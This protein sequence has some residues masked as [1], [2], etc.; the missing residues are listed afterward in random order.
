M[1]S[2]RALDEAEIRRRIEAGVAAI[3]AMD[4]E[5]VMALYA[6]D[7]VSFDVEPPL[8]H[9]GTEAKRKNW[10]AV[11][12]I[13]QAPLGYEV[14]DLSLSVGDDVAFAYSLNRISGTLRNGQRSEVWVRWTAG[15]RKVDGVWLITHDHASVPADFASGN[16][17]VDL[18]P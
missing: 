13:Y 14:R 3:R 6:P 18:E 5:G 16:A 10:S 15:L 7:I 12:T 1:A 2:Q 8:R 17:M 9:L 4:L 11:F